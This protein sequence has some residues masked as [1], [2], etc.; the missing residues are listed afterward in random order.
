M[1][2]AVAVSRQKEQTGLWSEDLAER[3]IETIKHSLCDSFHMDRMTVGKRQVTPKRSLSPKHL[4]RRAAIALLNLQGIGLYYEENGNDPE[5]AKKARENG[6]DWPEC[7]DTMIGLKRLDNVQH[8]VTD[9]IRRGIPGDLI[10]TGVWRGGSTI[11]MR[12]ILKALGDQD[13]TV[14]VADSFEGLPK[15]NAT[16]YAADAKDTHYLLDQL[17]VSVD[18]V[19]ANFAKYGL[20]D[21]QVQ[22][23]KGWFKDTLHVAPI[24]KLAVLRLDGDMYESTM[25]AFRALYHKL[26]PG[27]YCIVDDYGAVKSCKQATHD[28]RDQHGI[29]ETIQQVDWTGVFWQKRS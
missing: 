3:Y 27:G 15:P 13:R 9:V 21:D 8:C 1:S 7:A 6:T 25:D 2:A 23:L 24:E 26:S 28:F 22:F 29:T 20:L 16:T 17:R 4:V 10:E 11:F 19:K 5:A 12:A 18:Q 14:W